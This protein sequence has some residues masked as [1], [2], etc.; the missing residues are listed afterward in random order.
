[1]RGLA[2]IGV[3]K[4]LTEAGI[5][6]TVVAGTSV[7]SILGAALT[8]GMNW[9]ELATMAKSIFWPSLLSGKRLERFCASHL[10]ESFSHLNFPFAAVATTLPSRQALIITEGH[11]ASAISAS[12]AVRF[13]R[14]PVL[15]E[16]NFLKD[17]GIACVL[18]TLACRD[19]GAEV[20]IASDVWEI[21]SL[22]RSIGC[23]PDDPRT[24]RLYP[25][26]Y[27]LAL[28]HTDLLI[29]PPIPLAGYIPGEKAVTHMIAAGE[30]ATHR[31]LAQIQTK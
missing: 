26:H 18:P 3:I 17:G 1:M 2:H 19:L 4:A 11:L 25:R 10:P 22:L 8:R 27:R 12:C 7:G 5:R 28:Y 14:S 16:G 31:A 13:L 29:Q 15:R 20:V 9:S 24:G 21:G 6:F 30:A 23:R